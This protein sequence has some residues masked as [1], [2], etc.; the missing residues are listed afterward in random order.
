MAADFLSGYRVLDLGQYVPGPYAALILADL[1]AEV[2]KVE[3]PGGEPMRRFGPRPDDGISPFYRVMNGGKTVVSLDLKSEAGSRS[4]RALLEAADVLVES[5]RPGVLDRLGFGREV[6]DRLN[7]GLVH[8]ALS[9]YG[10]TGPYRLRA[11]HDLNYMALGGG[12]AA[13]GTAETPTISAPPVSDYASGV[14]AAATVMAALLGRARTG[15]GA[16]LDM[17]LAE[18][19][20]AWQSVG[21]AGLAHAGFRPRLAA[22][23]ING[24]L[25]CYQIYRTADGRFLTLGALE[26]KFWANFSEA[27]GHPEWAARQWEAM[28]QTA[29]IAEVAETVGAQ[30][31]AHWNA[32]L[33]PVDCCYQAVVDFDEIADHPQIRARGMI[34]GGGARPLEALYPAWIDG[35]PPDDRPAVREVD[36]ADVL[37]AWSQT[38]V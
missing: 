36:V 7:P 20:L 25:A 19:V 11:G 14:Q 28:P 13:S 8:C 24:G 4:F 38:G 18:T 32:L 30:D 22:N 26:E 5:Y 35:R 6:L 37:A 15:R 16:F 27:L 33:D 34:A 2:V 1:G 21:L 17:S 10:Q 23:L 9:G 3:P 29:L 12:L 31:L